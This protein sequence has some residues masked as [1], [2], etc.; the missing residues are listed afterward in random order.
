MALN[1]ES[2]RMSLANLASTNQD[3]F[4]VVDQGYKRGQSFGQDEY[5][6]MAR[7]AVRENNPEK[8]AKARALYD[9]MKLTEEE[10]GTK[11]TKD[12]RQYAADN[13]IRPDIEAAF[14]NLT[15]YLRENKDKVEADYTDPGFVTRV[16]K[17]FH[18]VG[19]LQNGRAQST[20]RTN[21]LT[22]LRGFGLNQAADRIEQSQKVY[23]HNVDKLNW[24]KNERSQDQVIQGIKEA[25]KHNFP[26]SI[27]RV[28]GFIR[29]AKASASEAVLGN[30][31][32][33][34]N[35]MAALS[36]MGSDEVISDNELLILMDGG[37]WAKFQKLFERT[38]GEG[39]KI[40]VSDV[41]N[42]IRSLNDLLA[43]IGDGYK[44][45]VEN[46]QDA[47]LKYANVEGLPGAKEYVDSYLKLVLPVLPADF[48]NPVDLSSLRQNWENKIG[49]G[50][51]LA[52]GKQDLVEYTDWVNKLNVEK[53]RLE[54]ANIRQVGSLDVNAK[55][56]NTANY[57]NR[58]LTSPDKI[59][60]GTQTTLE[61]LGFGEQTSGGG[62]VKDTTTDSASDDTNQQNKPQ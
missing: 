4:S 43:V 17:Y 16:G 37:L 19:R 8:L 45:K 61:A 24:Q 10:K 44:A 26:A 51:A 41:I 48:W 60:K 27:Q 28:L 1:T 40:G 6:S 56:L 14:D 47:S 18:L 30:P 34:K 52:F 13:E 62:V 5:V 55:A 32:A 42:A 49:T 58:I 38:L 29:A 50:R 57:D 25:L 3:P 33:S 35:L 31:V 39:S 22:L 23:E 2:I 15:E 20:Y 36:R 11:L 53:Q 21:I 54:Q 59:A 7:M 9:P 46:L 12:E